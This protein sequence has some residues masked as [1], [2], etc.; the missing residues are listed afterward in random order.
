MPSLNY[1]QSRVLT[2]SRI[3][4]QAVRIFGCESPL[5]EGFMKVYLKF[6]DTFV[7]TLADNIFGYLMRLI[8]TMY[9]KDP[10]N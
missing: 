5:F 4:L 8:E 10:S 1:V 6:A 2:S 7:E 3:E 9:Q